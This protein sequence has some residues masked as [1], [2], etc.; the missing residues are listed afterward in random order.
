MKR[1]Y[2]NRFQFDVVQYK[3]CDIGLYL[4]VNMDE[5]RSG[6]G[7]INGVVLWP[8]IIYFDELS[9]TRLWSS[10]GTWLMKIASLYTNL[11]SVTSKIKNFN[12]GY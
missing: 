8:K 6:K 9:A 7:I 5:A 3:Y 10:T 12:Y 4:Y 2:N 11:G 1:R